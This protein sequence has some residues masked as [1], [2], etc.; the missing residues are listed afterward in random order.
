MEDNKNNKIRIRDGEATK[1]K[2]IKT[3]EKLFSRKGFNGVSIRDLAK[4]CNMSGPL[5]LHHFGSKEGIYDAV[6]LELIKEYVPFFE[7]IEKEEKGLFDFIENIVRGTFEFHRK[8]PISLRL[9]NWD[10]L[11]GSKKRWP[12]TEEFKRIFVERIQKGIDNG[13]ITGGFSAKNFGLM[14]GGMIHLWW[15]ERQD[16]LHR[17]LGN[18]YT[19]EEALKADEEYIQQILWLIKNSLR[20]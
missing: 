15:E 6:R 18:K 20:K 4:A 7:D 5:I 19:A 9:M 16:I 14:I 8:N 3:A 2:I 17:R 1:K 11:D 13:E 12:K 10:R